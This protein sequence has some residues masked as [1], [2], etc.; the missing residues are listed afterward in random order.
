MDK[1]LG[2]NVR[3]KSTGTKPPTSI[4]PTLEECEDIP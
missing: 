1:K 2:D 3:A 4:D